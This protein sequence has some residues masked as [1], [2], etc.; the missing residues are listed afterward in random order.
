MGKVVGWVLFI[1]AVLL[2]VAMLANGADFKPD[3]LG[4]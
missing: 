4:V 3:A 1:S 2:V